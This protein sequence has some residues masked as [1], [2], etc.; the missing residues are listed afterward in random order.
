[1]R[2]ARLQTAL[3]RLSAAIREVESEVAALQANHDPLA[4]HIFRFAPRLP[5]RERHEKREALRSG[6]PPQLQRGM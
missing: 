6:C 5:N 3:H 4:S 2:A 1:M